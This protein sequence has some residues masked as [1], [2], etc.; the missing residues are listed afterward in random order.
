MWQFGI[1]SSYYPNGVS[2]CPFVVRWQGIGKRG[3][4]SNTFYLVIRKTCKR[5]FYCGPKFCQLIRIQFLFPNMI[6]QLTN[7]YSIV[8]ACK[9]I[10]SSNSH[11]GTIF[12]HTHVLR[13]HLNFHDITPRIKW[14]LLAFPRRLWVRLWLWAFFWF[15]QVGIPTHVAFIGKWSF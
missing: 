10:F 11:F 6:L 14:L 13:H 9:G 7:A 4:D 15:L 5:S 1:F 8:W 12:S 2:F 3:F